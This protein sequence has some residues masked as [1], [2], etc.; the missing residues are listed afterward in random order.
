MRVLPVYR[1]GL[2]VYT[3]QINY[4]NKSQPQV[5]GRC[6]FHPCMGARQTCTQG[7]INIQIILNPKLAGDASFTCTRECIRRVY[8][9]N[10]LFK[11]F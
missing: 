9:A 2:D 4:L 5:G 6:E 1:S 10:Q 11:N 7:K 3:W 8:N